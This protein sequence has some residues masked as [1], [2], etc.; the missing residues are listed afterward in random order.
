M[1]SSRVRRSQTTTSFGPAVRWS[2][3]ALPARRPKV[4][5][6]SGVAAA[7]SSP[8]AGSLGSLGRRT[9][10][11]ALDVEEEAGAT[12]VMGLWRAQPPAARIKTNGIASL[13]CVRTVGIPQLESR[14]GAKASEKGNT[15]W[16]FFPQ[17]SCAGAPG[18]TQDRFPLHAL[19][20]ARASNRQSDLDFR[21]SRRDPGPHGMALDQGPL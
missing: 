2:G 12:G 18:G 15:A 6:S 10:C 21:V 4:A 5:R 20:V 17:R 13:M 8:G 16:P 9:K 7:S 3:A 11:G 19:G 14:V 1:P